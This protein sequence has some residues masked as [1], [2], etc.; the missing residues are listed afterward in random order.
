MT[1]NSVSL[2]INTSFKLVFHRCF[3][4]LSF[5]PVVRVRACDRESDR[6]NRGSN[7]GL[8]VFVFFVFL[9]FFL[10]CYYFIIFYKK[11]IFVSFRF[12]K[13]VR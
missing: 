6:E 9:L 4:N 5:S 10:F 3:H 13:V 11:M 1:Y 12:Y 7:P 2:N 8:C